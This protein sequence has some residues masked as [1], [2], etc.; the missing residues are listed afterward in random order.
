[1]VALVGVGSH[2]R[3]IMAI[4]QACGV[5]FELYDDDPDRG[6]PTRGVPR[7]EPYI[8]GMNHPTERGQYAARFTV[9]RLRPALALV[10]PS[11]VVGP[12]CRLAPGVVVAPN[13]TML[14]EVILNEHVHVNYQSSMTRCTVGA[15]TTISP[16]VTICGDVKIGAECFI[17]AG[18]VISNLVTIGNGVTVGAGAVVL[19]DV[20]DGELV[21]GVPARAKAGI[22]S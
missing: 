19:D 7:S 20:P 22:C 15:F 12:S 13:V 4:G 10:H 8:L 17:G 11:A 3:D 2:G 6:K 16:G 9:A 14:R 5:E 18:A 21:V 1:M